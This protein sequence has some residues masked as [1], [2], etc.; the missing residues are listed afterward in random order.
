MNIENFICKK[1]GYWRT[2]ESRG[3]VVSKIHCDVCGTPMRKI[4]LIQM[5]LQL[6]PP[7]KGGR[8]SCWAYKVSGLLDLV[9]LSFLVA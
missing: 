9:L 6:D 4:E 1:C 8:K 5:T 3:T 2:V 7:P